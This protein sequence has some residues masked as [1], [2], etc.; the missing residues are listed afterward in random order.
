LVWLVAKNKEEIIKDVSI[1]DDAIKGDPD[2]P[3]TIVEFSDYQCPFCATFYKNILP[4]I[5]EQYIDTGIAKLVYRDFPLGGH[6]HAQKAAEASECAG[7]QGKFW[8][9]HDILFENQD[10]WETVGTGKFK[11]Y[12][13]TLELDS[14]TFD[15]CLDGGEMADEVRADFLAGRN[16]GVT[17]TPY[18]FIDGRPL[19]GAQPFSEFSALIDK[20]VEGGDSCLID[21]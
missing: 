18:F 6:A 11:E 9:Y 19:S 1:D 3:V 2:A 15:A 7:E 5:Q 20:C 16:Y 14:E 10:D 13:G 4:Q 8:E 21:L 17:G 12:A